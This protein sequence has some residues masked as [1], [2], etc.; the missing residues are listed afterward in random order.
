V[1]QAALLA[2]PARFAFADSVP[3]AAT[4]ARLGRELEH[5]HFAR[6][7]VHGHAFVL[8]RP[9]LESDGIHYRRLKGFPPKRPALITTTNWD[10]VPAPANPIAWSDVERVDRQ[11]RHT[12]PG[13]P[14]GGGLGFWGGS[15]LGLAAGWYVF[16]LTDSVV[17]F[18]AT[19]GAGALGGAI[20]GAHAM[21][22]WNEWEPVYPAVV[23][24]EGK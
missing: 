15:F 16:Y 22:E 19:A 24:N 6:V 11:V 18:W 5:P 13:L 14:I 9:R 2:L 1:V 23:S 20:L 17:G 8:D 7:T 12:G 3:D 4:L 10:S 21:G